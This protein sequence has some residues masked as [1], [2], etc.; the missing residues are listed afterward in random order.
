MS[1][2]GFPLATRLQ[3]FSRRGVEMVTAALC[4]RRPFRFRNGFSGFGYHSWRRGCR[5][6]LDIVIIVEAI[7]DDVALIE[8]MI[9]RRVAIVVLDPDVLRRAR[10]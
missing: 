2:R 5:L 9:L 10:N 6:L 7:N 4:E 8:L 3:G 1:G